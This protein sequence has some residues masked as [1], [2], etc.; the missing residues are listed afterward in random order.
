VVSDLEVRTSDSGVPP[1]PSTRA[2]TTSINS[3]ALG[4]ALDQIV[5]VGRIAS[6]N[7]ISTTIST[8]VVT[9]LTDEKNIAMFESA[10]VCAA[11]GMWVWTIALYLL[12]AILYDMWSL[13]LQYVVHRDI[14]V[15]SAAS[16][17]LLILNVLATSF[18]LQAIPFLGAVTRFVESC[19]L[20]P[21]GEVC[22]CGTDW[23]SSRNGLFVTLG[24]ALVCALTSFASLLLVRAGCLLRGGTVADHGPHRVLSLAKDVQEVYVYA[25]WRKEELSEV[26]STAKDD[27]YRCYGV[28]PVWCT[29][30]LGCC[31]TQKRKLG[32][33]LRCVLQG[34]QRGGRDLLGIRSPGPPQEGRAE[35]EVNGAHVGDAGAPDDAVLGSPVQNNGDSPI[36]FGCISPRDQRDVV[37]YY[38][39]INGAEG[40]QVLLRFVSDGSLPWVPHENLVLLIVFNVRAGAQSLFLELFNGTDLIEDDG[41]LLTV[42]KRVQ[43]TTVSTSF[44]EPLRDEIVKIICRELAIAQEPNLPNA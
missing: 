15:T 8:I 10:E 21:P 30:C 35:V 24:I 20:E 36:L 27:R 44:D 31:F 32:R 26:L 12:A 3:Q 34:L 33:R 18:L 2:Q 41:V 9:T 28:W 5:S 16:F 38:R 37:V 42:G 6:V 7:A 29:Q 1:R 17:I 25:D 39:E 14:Q 22:K 23:S 19:K 13:R 11:S 43:S 4:V 40:D